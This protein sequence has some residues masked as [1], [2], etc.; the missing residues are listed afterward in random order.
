VDGSLGLENTTGGGERRGNI[1]SVHE[2]KP[3][4]SSTS[5]PT[6]PHAGE[7]IKG[8]FPGAHMFIPPRLCPNF[9]WTLE[10]VGWDKEGEAKW[11]CTTP[12]QSA[13]VCQGKKTKVTSA[14]KWNAQSLTSGLSAF[15]WEE[16]PAK[17]TGKGHDVD[18]N[19]KKLELTMRQQAL[20]VFCA[21]IIV[22]QMHPL[23]NGFRFDVISSYSNSPL[24]KC[25]EGKRLS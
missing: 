14:V 15:E 9:A 24:Q 13:G 10:I 8:L 4:L 23:A 1:P 3:S 16:R 20:T 12:W 25:G 21:T 19:L 22:V 18:G 5:L 6:T 11:K 7:Q 17:T 2:L